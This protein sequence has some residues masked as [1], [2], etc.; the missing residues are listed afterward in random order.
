PPPPPPPPP[1]TPPPPPPPPTHVVVRRQRQM[2]I[3]DSFYYYPVFYKNTKAINEKDLATEK[4]A[5]AIEIPISQTAPSFATRHVGYFY[6]AE[7]GVY[8]FAL[9]S[10]D[11]SVLK[12]GGNVLIDNDGMH[13]SVEKSAQIALEKGYHPFELFFVEGGGGYTLQLQC[14]T[15]KGKLEDVNEAVFFH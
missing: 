7:T 11:G 2:C 5:K 3:R 12:I 8:S 1:P 15:P 14:K 4:I 10:D 6:A 9:R 13:S